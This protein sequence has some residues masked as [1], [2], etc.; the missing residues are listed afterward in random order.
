MTQ[1][2]HAR[3]MRDAAEARS[4]Q[5]LKDNKCWDDLNK[6]HN[7]CAMLL[8]SH[9]HLS[10]Y[11]QSK[12]LIACVVDKEMLAQNIKLLAS[13]LTKLTGELAE[14]H[15]Q[16][17]GKTGGSQDADEV[18]GTIEIYE[19]YNLF[20]ERHN[21]V[22]M[23][24]ANHIVE[25]FR[26]AELRLKGALEI[27]TAQAGETDPSVVTDV[28]FKEVPAE[29]PVDERTAVHVTLDD[30]DPKPQETVEEV[31]KTS[32]R[33]QTSCFNHVDEAA[34]FAS[35]QVEAEAA[36]TTTQEQ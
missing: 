6:I 20:T 10:Q 7:D 35:P 2:S 30:N 33:G 12:D 1:K 17:L 28:A 27:A 16:H 3:L 26:E 4:K 15:T 19:R 24:T 9:V 29:V 25:Q 5:D 14:I 18:F 34:F 22:V 23:P 11:S 31:V 13:D 36:A 21:A 8:L 32:A